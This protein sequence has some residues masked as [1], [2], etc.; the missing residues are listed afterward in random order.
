MRMCIPLIDTNPTL[1]QILADLRDQPGEVLAPLRHI[2]MDQ[3]ISAAARRNIKITE[4]RVA[5]D[6]LGNLYFSAADV[7]GIEKD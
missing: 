3:V 5:R 4:G 6:D 1:S 7:V 2:T